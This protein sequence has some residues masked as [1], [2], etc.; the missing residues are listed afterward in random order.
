MDK[1]K[2]LFLG[3]SIDLSILCPKI[4]IR[5]LAPEIQPYAREGKNGHVYIS[6]AISSRKEPS[7][8]GQTHLL[9]C[10]KKGARDIIFG[11]FKDFTKEDNNNV[12]NVNHEDSKQENHK[13]YEEPKSTK[14]EVEDDLPF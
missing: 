10:S 3:G 11:D 7:T 12:S 8:Y 4:G 9:K 2:N 6:S 13:S 5:H 14:N 1:I